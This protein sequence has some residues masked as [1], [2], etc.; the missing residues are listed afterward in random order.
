MW[1][2]AAEADGTRRTMIFL[3]SCLLGIAVLLTGL[4]IWYWLMTRPDDDD[5]SGDDDLVDDLP[6]PDGERRP[7]PETETLATEP[8]AGAFDFLTV[9]GG[10]QPAESEPEDLRRGEPLRP[11][12]EPALLDLADAEVSASPGTDAAAVAPA[13]PT[14]PSM[15]PAP[16]AT[17]GTESADTSVQRAKV[18]LVAA[19]AE[20]VS[21]T[22]DGSQ[23]LSD[24]GWDA[25]RR[26]V[27][28]KFHR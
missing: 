19:D 26:S 8:P 24:D 15:E 1:V 18:D 16:G 23:E 17:G 21:E 22:D 13:P 28:D 11:D 6:G 4:T 10:P 2:A 9:P 12:P 7:E 20:L 5:E 25:L 3:I 27:L 14:M